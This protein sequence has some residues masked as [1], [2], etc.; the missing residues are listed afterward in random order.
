MTYKNLTIKTFLLALVTTLFYSVPSIAQAEDKYLWCDSCDTV[1]KLETQAK[2]N[3]VIGET[4]NIYVMGVPFNQMKKYEV[5]K[6]FIGYLE[7]DNGGEPDGRG[8]QMGTIKTPRYSLT[9]T[10]LNIESSKKTTFNELVGVTKATEDLLQANPVPPEIAGSV[11][12]IVGQSYKETEIS[13]YYN[14]NHSLIEYTTLRFTMMAQLMNVV[15]PGT[16]TIEFTF[17]DNSSAVFTISYANSNGDLV[18][19]F[20]E[21]VDSNGNVVKAVLSNGTYIFKDQGSYQAYQNALGALGIPVVN[22]SASTAAGKVV[23]SGG[24]QVYTCV[25]TF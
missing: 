10:E 22:G 11:W 25:Y 2:L 8:G 14:N 20:K 19:R 6:T 3:A 17:S 5:T 18:L 9:L 21:G 4:I 15:N 13:D 1:S 7:V 12:E 23:C 24:G 16:M